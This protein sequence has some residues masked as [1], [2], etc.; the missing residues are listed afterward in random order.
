[1]EYDRYVGMGRKY[2]AVKVSTLKNIPITVSAFKIFYVLTFYI[3]L[4]IFNVVR[5]RLRLER[6][7]K[8]EGNKLVFDNRLEGAG[9]SDKLRK[10]RRVL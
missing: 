3:I 8:Q 6:R 9:N 5:I 2:G 7:E 1:M 10:H 4:F